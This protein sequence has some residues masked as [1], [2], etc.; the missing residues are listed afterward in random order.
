M[1]I[2]V[3]R[4]SSVWKVRTAA[5]RSLTALCQML[6][7]LMN[8]FLKNFEICHTPLTDQ[9]FVLWLH[10]TGLSLWISALDMYYHACMRMPSVLGLHRTHWSPQALCQ[11][12]AKFSDEFFFQE[13]SIWNIALRDQARAVLIMLERQ[14]YAYIHR[15]AQN[16]QTVQVLRNNIRN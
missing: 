12:D 16:A 7:S 9:P 15:Y 2:T 5:G 13:L 1:R 11:L 6:S 8:A 3:V 14:R 10:H 4:A